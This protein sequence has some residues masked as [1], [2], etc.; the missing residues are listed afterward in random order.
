MDG[1]ALRSTDL[2]AN[3]PLPVAGQSFAGHPF[4]GECPAGYCIRIMTGASIPAGTDTVIMQ[5]KAELTD[6]GIRC[7][8]D[9][10][11]GNN[12]RKTGEDIQEGETVLSAGR[13]RLRPQDIGLLASLGIARVQVFRKLK[14]SIFS[15]GDEL[16]QP[17]RRWALA[18]YTTAIAIHFTPCCNVLALMYWIM[19]AFRMIMTNCTKR[20]QP[21]T[22]KSMQ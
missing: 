13:R 1:Y 2:A 4:T 21:R 6:Q 22:G 7:L 5:E 18:T 9:S 19:A 8:T 17:K 10:Q 16:R 11:P 15:I 14:V 12:V 3:K 20:S